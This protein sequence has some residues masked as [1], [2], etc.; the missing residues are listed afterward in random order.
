MPQVFN[1]PDDVVLTQWDIG[2]DGE[3]IRF[4]YYPN[5][6]GAGEFVIPKQR[7]IAL[8]ITILQSLANGD[9]R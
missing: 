7:A 5:A 8:V 6:I 1:H 3:N 2:F 9:L 4:F